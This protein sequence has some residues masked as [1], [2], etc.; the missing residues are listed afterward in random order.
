MANK[1]LFK[2]HF[3][4]QRFEGQAL[5]LDILADLAALQEVIIELAKSDY[6][7]Q[8]PERKRVPRG[9]SSRVELSLTGIERGSAV[10]VISV[11]FLGSSAF[12]PDHELAWKH[13]QQ[14]PEKLVEAL[15]L[16]GQGRA[17]PQDFP[18]KV[19]H[20]L[21]KFGRS[22]RDDEFVELNAG[23]KTQ[24]LRYD[25]RLRE[26]V[27]K[28]ALQRDHSETLR[29][30]GTIPEAD[31]D[32]KNFTLMQVDG[33]RYLMP[34]DADMSQEILKA[35]GNY[36]GGQRVEVQ[37]EAWLDAENNIKNIIEIKAIDLID[38]LDVAAQLDDLRL[39]KDGWLDGLGKA[40][41]PSAL[42]TLTRWF[43][44]NGPMDYPLPHIYPTA[45]GGVRAEWRFGSQD[46]S[47]EFDFSQHTADW[48]CLDLDSDKE[49]AKTLDFNAA[50]DNNWVFAQ[51]QGMQEGLA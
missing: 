34:F 12:G 41:D 50:K 4:G 20:S 10:P 11:N 27:E 37:C 44:L 7:A 47:L 21:K 46:I 29:L 26:K 39:L 3:H 5:P 9:F 30:R 40:P 16:I 23:P 49:E 38:P 35:F 48:H 28:R 14:A 17:L 22:L 51:L 31:Q 2:P 6:L 42:D 8:N 25:Q 45:E 32:K 18:T 33:R 19:L 15:N 36:R 13:L 24:G 1:E 43:E